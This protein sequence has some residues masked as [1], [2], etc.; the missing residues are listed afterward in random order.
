MNFEKGIQVV[1]KLPADF[2]MIGQ[3]MPLDTDEQE[4]NRPLREFLKDKQYLKQAL[5]ETLK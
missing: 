5:L 1:D 2:K 3:A 4:A